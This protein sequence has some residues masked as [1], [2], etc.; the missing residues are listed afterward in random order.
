MKEFENGGIDQR[1][2]LF[3]YRLSSAR[4]EIECSFGR[5]KARFGSLSREIDIKLDNLP[6]LPHLPQFVSF[7]SNSCFIFYNFCEMRKKGTLEK[8]LQPSIENNYKVNNARQFY[9]NYFE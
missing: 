5:L 6:H 7:A 4:M 3:G 1:E 9:V 2:K 8:E